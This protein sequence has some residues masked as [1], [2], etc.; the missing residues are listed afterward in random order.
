[1]CLFSKRLNAF[2]SVP[3]GKWHN[4]LTTQLPIHRLDSPQATI[5]LTGAA[6][7]FTTSLMSRSVK[8]IPSTFP[9]AAKGLWVGTVP[10]IKG[11]GACSP[12][13]L[14]QAHRNKSTW[15]HFSKNPG[16]MLRIS[17]IRWGECFCIKRSDVACEGPLDGAQS[18]HASSSALCN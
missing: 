10:P 2:P 5:S 4:L 9:L 16:T 7:L 14:A 15:L 17:D 3:Y 18:S 12:G 11:G 1:M 13:L 8:S 6:S